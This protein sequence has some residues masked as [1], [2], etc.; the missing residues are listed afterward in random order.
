MKK[1]QSDAVPKELEATRLDEK[2]LKAD[3]A[4]QEKARVEADQKAEK[5]RL[6]TIKQKEDADLKE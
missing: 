1:L 2:K 3:V 6:A 4:E 5:A